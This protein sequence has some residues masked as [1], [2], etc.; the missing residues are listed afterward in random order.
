MD[1]AGIKADNGTDK[2]KI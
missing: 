2:R 1:F